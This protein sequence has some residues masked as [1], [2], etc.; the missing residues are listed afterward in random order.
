MCCSLD[1][2]SRVHICR[3]LLLCKMISPGV[4]PATNDMMI[5]YY[6]LMTKVDWLRRW[7]DIF[8]GGLSQPWEKG[9]QGVGGG[10][11]VRA[12]AVGDRERGRCCWAGGTDWA[13]PGRRRELGCGEG[14]R[15]K[16]KKR[17]ELG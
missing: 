9:R 5:L 7:Y 10:A 1:S 2:P 3:S 15:K 14:K 17:A 16:R 4:N 11:D 12:P 8:L 13:K 6:C